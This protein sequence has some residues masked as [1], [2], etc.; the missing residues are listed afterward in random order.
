VVASKLLPKQLHVGG[1]GFIAAL[2]AAGA[3]VLPFAVG[4]VAQVR[5]LQVVMPAV[6]VMLEA[7]GVVWRVL[8]GLKVRSRIGGPEGEVTEVG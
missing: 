2:G 5:G 6:L 1:I 3:C 7:D 8:L 4:G